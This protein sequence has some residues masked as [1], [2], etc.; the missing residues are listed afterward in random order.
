MRLNLGCGS[1]PMDGYVNV[2]SWHQPGVD[3]VHDLDVFPWP[4][5]DGEAEE[6]R[7]FDIYEHVDYPLEF[8][9][10]CHRILQPGATLFIHTGHWRDMSSY[11]DPTHKR[12][13]TEESFDYWVPGTYLNG[14]YGV[15]YARGRHFEKADIHL[16]GGGS[17]LMSVTLRKILGEQMAGAIYQ[18][19]GPFLASV[20]GTQMAIQR[21]T[22]VREGHPLLAGR[23]HLFEPFTVDFEYGPPADQPAEPPTDPEPTTGDVKPKTPRV[24]AKTAE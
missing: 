16:D 19:K 18:A 17:G 7:A 2:D 15:A 24:R 10:E 1:Q 14:R 3:V 4:W 12:F 11:T 13:L 20:D 22:T 21:G 23:E 6:I 5:K 8:M 9:G